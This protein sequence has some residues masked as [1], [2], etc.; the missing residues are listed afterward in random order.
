MNRRKLMCRMATLTGSAIVSPSVSLAAL[1][2]NLPDVAHIVP[3][4]DHD[5]INLYIGVDLLA[6]VVSSP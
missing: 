5:K 6:H 1:W 4:E 3:N 2:K